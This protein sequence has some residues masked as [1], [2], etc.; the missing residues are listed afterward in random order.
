MPTVLVGHTE[1]RTGR[2]DIRENKKGISYL[3]GHREVR[4]FM[5]RFAKDYKTYNRWMKRGAEMV[6]AEAKRSV[7]INKGFLASKLVGRASV[8]G[9]DST[10]NKKT[11]FGGVVV[12]GTIYAKSISFGRWYQVGPYQINRGDGP[13]T[14]YR[15]AE[16]R[17]QANPYLKRARDRSRPNIVNYWNNQ[18]SIYCKINGFEYVRS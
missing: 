14:H 1:V 7:P 16:I 9:L 11:F 8:R 18:I 6:A 13:K 3:S 5:L 12:G 15:Y 17:T 10:G 4:N 2:F